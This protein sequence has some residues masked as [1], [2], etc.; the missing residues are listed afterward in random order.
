MSTARH[1]N[2]SPQEYLQQER[3]AL[4]KSEYVA[5]QVTAMAGA[6]HRHNLITGNV[7]GE[8]RQQLKGRPCEVYPSDLRLFNVV[9]GLYTYPDVTIVCGKPEF[10]DGVFDTLVNPI[11]LCEVLSESTENWDRG[12]KAAH[13]RQ[14]PSLQEYILISQSEP[15]IEQFQRQPDGNWLLVESVG[16]EGEIFIP[17]VGIHIPIREIYARVAWPDPE[18]ETSPAMQPN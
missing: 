9:T 7:I 16:L 10:S 5:G 2:I 6:S 17:S 4:F 11:V 1:L 8:T 14:I 13:Y 12:R 3:R 15:R 18:L